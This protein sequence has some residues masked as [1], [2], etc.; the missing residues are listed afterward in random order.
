MHRDV[1]IG[2]AIGVLLIALI[3]VFWWAREEGQPPASP[4]ERG[5]VEGMLSPSMEPVAPWDVETESGLPEGLESIAEKYYGSKAEWRLIYEANRSRI[6][7]DPNR[8]K[9][10][11]VLI[12]PPER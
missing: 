3:A 6:G 10:G 7:A 12:I 11:V 1:K 2:I 8:L 5:E 4:L 9:Q